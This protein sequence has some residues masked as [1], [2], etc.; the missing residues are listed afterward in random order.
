[1]QPPRSIREEWFHR[2]RLME[3]DAMTS[4]AS[5]EK[6]STRLWRRYGTEAF[7]LLEAIRA[8][9][10]NAEVL[11]ENAEYLRC[12]IEQAARREMV[13]NLED[14]LRRRS[15]ISL[16]VSRDALVN[17]AGLKE[18]CQILFGDQADAK[19]REYF[20]TRHG[21][22]VTEPSPAA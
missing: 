15:K 16:V 12:E 9:P 22:T 13:V 8:D 5:S 19:W 2:A 14:F 18:A 10:G 3:L 11:I 20:A 17:A 21:T 7:A 6:L 1:M 4:P